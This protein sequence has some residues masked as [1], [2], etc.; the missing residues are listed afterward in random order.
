[1]FCRIVLSVSLAASS[2]LIAPAIAAAC[3]NAMFVEDDAAVKQVAEAER[4][5][6]RGKLTEAEEKVHPRIYRFDA[7][8]VRRRAEV[9]WAA[10]VFRGLGANA[11]SWRVKEG[12]RSLEKQLMADKDSPVLLARI[13]EGQS[14]APDTHAAALASLEDLAKR[15]L[16]P[17]AF[18]Y[19]TLAQL[20]AGAGDKAAALAALEVCKSMTKRKAVC[21]LQP[22]KAN[23]QK[24]EGKSE[25]QLRGR[26]LGA[27]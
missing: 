2:V 26:V 1:M 4:L 17:D 9:V 14:L 21:S 5:L 25:K 11:Q 20:R 8:G 22:R 18:A 6:V 27:R 13:A 3:G 16:M 15:D 7:P 19:R 10:A 23:A 12:L 24:N